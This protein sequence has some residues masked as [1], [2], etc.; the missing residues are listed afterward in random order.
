MDFQCLYGVGMAPIFAGCMLW[1]DQFMTVTNKIGGLM[2][3]AGGTGAGA[4]P[5]FVGQFIVKHPML[6]MYM[7]FSLM[8]FCVLLF[9]LASW[10]G[11]RAIGA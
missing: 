5:L 9:A 7:E 10:I 8:Y 6:L 3:V 11:K 4:F 2:T 1:M